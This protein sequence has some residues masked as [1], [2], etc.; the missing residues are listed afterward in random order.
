MPNTAPYTNR[1][2]GID[3]IVQV[4]VTLEDL[5]ASSN[6]VDVHHAAVKHSF[7]Q[8]WNSKFRKALVKALVEQTGI[9]VPSSGKSRTNRKG[10]TIDIPISEND[11][12][13][14]LLN[15]NHVTEADYLVLGQQIADSIPFEVSKKDEDADPAPKFYT[16][17]RQLLAMVEAGTIG[18]DGNPI[19]EEGFVTKWT[20][21]NPGYNFENLGGFTEDGIARALEID[22]K[23][24]SL[25][26]PAGLV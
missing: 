4:P 12:I 3:A 13:K 1:T 5:V 10:E 17:A 18:S 22:D 24:R 16:L 8:G 11:Y 14:H 7:Y 21:A 6:P 20:A 15:N 2:L 23:R 26:L 25:A 9:A 19:T